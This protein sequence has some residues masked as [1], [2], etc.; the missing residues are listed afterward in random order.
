[1]YEAPVETESY[2]G[3]YEEEAPVEE[4]EEGRGAAPTEEEAPVEGTEEAAPPPEEAA[5]PEGGAAA[6]G[7]VTAG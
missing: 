4:V 5:P 2:E 3:E 6:G 7:G 1:E